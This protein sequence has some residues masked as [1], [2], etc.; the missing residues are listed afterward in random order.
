[1]KT[2]NLS[3]AFTLLEML[4][5]V[6]IIGI[7]AALLLPAVSRVKQ[8]GQKVECINNTRQLYL[9]WSMYAHDNDDRL[10]PN[11]D[12]GEGVAGVTNWIAGSIVLSNEVADPSIL[13]DPNRS[14]LA[15]Y[16]KSPSVLKC[17]ADKSRNVRSMSMNNRMNP[18]KPA[19]GP[20]AFTAG[21]GTNFMNFRTLSEIPQPSEL[22]VFLDERSDTI[23]DAYFCVDMTNTGEPEGVGVPL[24]H[25]IID[26]P[27]SYHDGASAITFA[28]GHTEGHRWVEPTTTP[29]LGTAV[30]RTYTSTEDRDVAWLQKHATVRINP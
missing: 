27:A 5:V 30:A 18:I 13:V 4:V 28:D 12:A 9:A 8:K 22:F 26:F 15:A 14:L 7:L 3:R 10:P 11:M 24:P 29:P 21:M 16:L 17:P 1:M 19:G 25:F 2:H 20:T 6:A 23:N